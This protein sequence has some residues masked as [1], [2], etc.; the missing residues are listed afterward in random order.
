[1]FPSAVD[2]SAVG[3]PPIIILKLYS[4]PFSFLIQDFLSKQDTSFPTLLVI[5][6][7][8]NH[9]M[10]PE[11]KRVGGERLCLSNCFNIKSLRSVCCRGHLSCYIDV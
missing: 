2:P 8:R 10:K 1:M 4:L 9:S 11:T 3:I 6:H 7:L 5:N